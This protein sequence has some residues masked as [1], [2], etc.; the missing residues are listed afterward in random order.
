MMKFIYGSLAL[1]L[2]SSLASGQT[3]QQVLPSELKQQTVIQEPVT[4]RKGFFRTSFAGAYTFID[5]VFDEN[6]DK[7]YILGTIGWERSWT[8]NISLQYGITDRLQVMLKPVFH[9]KKIFYSDVLHF[10]TT[11][12]TA[13]ANVS[14]IGFGDLVLGLDYQILQE[15]DTRPSIVARSFLT[16]PTGRKNPTAIKDYKDFKLPTGTG[17]FVLA[18]ELKTR[19]IIFP[20]SITFNVGYSY[21]FEGEKIFYPD[22]PEDEMIRF[23]TGNRLDLG[24]SFNFHLNDWIALQNQV[25]FFHWGSNKIFADPTETGFK[26]WVLS[27]QPTLNF[28]IRRFRLYE[29]V[30]IPV[31]GKYYPADPFYVLGLLYTF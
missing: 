11:I 10:G 29:V 31:L 21:S 12:E 5:K 18:L 28:Q 1:L 13:Y 3:E 20:Y 27:Y 9:N 7:G 22:Y 17:E 2:M 15:T 23:N 8:Y 24:G 26:S 4:L 19:K 30:F 16:F 25:V 14:G 6:G